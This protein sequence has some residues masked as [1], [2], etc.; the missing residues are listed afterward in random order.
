MQHI[1]QLVDANLNILEVFF[2]QFLCPQFPVLLQSMKNCRINVSLSIFIRF[3]DSLKNLIGNYRQKIVF[4]GPRNEIAAI[5]NYFLK[6]EI[7]EF[8]GNLSSPVNNGWFRVHALFFMFARTWVR[9][10]LGVVLI[11]YF[12]PVLLSLNNGG[13]YWI[14]LTLAIFEAISGDIFWPLG[15]RPLVM[16]LRHNIRFG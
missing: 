9:I 12:F 6:S 5:N 3:C 13:L 10:W 4:L 15:Q 1:R 16:D 2:S 14:K 11:F 7:D 8:F